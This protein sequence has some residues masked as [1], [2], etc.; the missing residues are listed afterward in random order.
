MNA[1][2]QDTRLTCTRD[3]GRHQKAWFAQLRERV[4]NGEP[5]A[6]VGVDVPH[7]ILVAMDIPYVVAPWWA[8][9]CAANAYARRYLDLM[10]HRGYPSGQSQYAALGFASS[11]AD[12]SDGPMGGLPTPTFFVTQGR[13]G[14]AHTIMELWAKEVG[15][16]HLV[17]EKPSDPDPA[18]HWWTTIRHDWESV[19]DS[20]CLDLA[21]AQISAFVGAVERITGRTLDPERLTV[22]MNLVN[23]QAEL[24][25]RARDLINC[26]IPAPAGIAQTIPATTIPQWH[27]GTVWGRDAARSFLDELTAKSAQVKNNPRERFRMMWVGNPVWY[28]LDMYRRLRADHDTEFIWSM[29]LAIAADGSPRT[30]YGTVYRTLASRHVL[31]TDQLSTPPW[32]CHWIADQAVRAGVDGVVNMI[33]QGV[34]RGSRFI[35]D[36]LRARGI[37]VIDIEAD[38]VDSQAAGA[39]SVEARVIDFIRSL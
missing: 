2:M 36:A 26:A 30:D 27:A 17:L 22:A 32:N 6:V 13:S 1:S 20:D 8:S 15:A 10:T 12:D 24:F 21:E 19:I 37:P 28:D 4:A 7:E 14:P 16:E 23:E 39:T 9:V 35:G 29:Y 3:F 18:D 34:P 25:S 5:L 38:A 11:L 31:H 33:S